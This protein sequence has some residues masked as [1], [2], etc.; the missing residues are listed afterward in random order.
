MKKYSWF[1]LLIG[2][3]FLL[4]CAKETI[5]E[6]VEVQKGSIIHSGLTPPNN[7]I[8]SIGDYY[9]DLS[10][11]NLY[12]SKTAEGWGNPINLKG[13]QGEK[14]EPG[15]PGDKGDKGDPGRPGDKGDKGDPGKKGDK[16]DPGRPG[17]KG[18]KGD[19]GI[20]GIPGQKGDPGERGE[21]GERG[22]KGERG[23]QGFKGEPGPKGEPGAPGKQGEPGPK[24]EPGAPGKQGEPGPKGEPGAPGK[25]GEPGPKGEPGAPGKQ[26][27]PGPKGEP[28]APGKQGEP[29]PKGEPGAPG[30]QGEPGAKGEP[31]AP[32]ASGK[33]I[34]GLYSGNGKPLDKIGQQGDFYIDMTEKRLYGPKT[35]DGWSDQFISLAPS[36]SAPIYNYI[37]ESVTRNDG[38]FEG[39]VL[40]EWLS[41]SA[42]QVNMNDIEELKKVG[43]IDDEAFKNCNSL[44]SI[45]LSDNIEYINDDAFRSLTNLKVVILSA[46]L[47]EIASNAFRNTEIKEITIPKNV[48]TIGSMAFAYCKNLETVIFESD[49]PD[50]FDYQRPNYGIF[51]ECKKLKNI[52]VP[53]K[54]YDDYISN[55]KWEIYRDYIKINPK[56]KR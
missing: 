30:K 20:Q 24:G 21:R 25:Q 10:S 29:G 47:K 31:G 50:I 33:P 43:M 17:D 39:I 8:G 37:I 5:V 35:S 48:R 52:Y 44:E 1:A 6:R 42:K 12:G 55:E 27:E 32:G 56:D 3:L 28:G 51:A 36:S 7:S 54:S 38:K 18:D 46:H 40:I 49:N 16:G 2:T 23:K 26:G 34:G 41:K 4:S 45:R 9:L 11:Y 14:G 15:R 53:D 22:L 13:I 19:P